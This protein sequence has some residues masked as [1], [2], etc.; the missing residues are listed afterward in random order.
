MWGKEGQYEGILEY[1]RD[2]GHHTATILWQN[3]SHRQSRLQL[4]ELRL[5][6]VFLCG[7]Y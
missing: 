7:L 1:I 5:F 4:L 3:G 6:V 2:V